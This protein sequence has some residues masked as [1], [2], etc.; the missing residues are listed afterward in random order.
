MSVS[1]AHQGSSRVIESIFLVQAFEAFTVQY[2]ALEKYENFANLYIYIYTRSL[3]PLRGPTS[4]W[5]TD[6]CDGRTEELGI[7]V[8]GYMTPFSC[9]VKDNLTVEKV[10]H[11]AGNL[12]Q[13]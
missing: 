8:S 1:R 7:L 3:G 9:E 11:V 4:S 10:T 5:R 12:S 6:F 13:F 2:I